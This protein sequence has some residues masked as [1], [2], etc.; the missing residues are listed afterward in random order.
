MHV[1]D[2]LAVRVETFQEAPLVEP[3]L[4]GPGLRLRTGLVCRAERMP[5][6]CSGRA[7]CVG[8]HQTVDRWANDVRL[9]AHGGQVCERSGQSRRSVHS[10]SGC[11]EHECPFRGPS[12]PGS[13]PIAWPKNTVGASERRTTSDTRAHTRSRAPVCEVG[14]HVPGRDGVQLATSSREARPP[15]RVNPRGAELPEAVGPAHAQ[16]ATHL[17]HFQRLS[18]RHRLRQAVGRVSAR[19][20]TLTGDEPLA[21]RRRPHPPSG[22]AAAQRPRCLGERARRARQRPRARAALAAASRQS[23]L[24]PWPAVLAAL[25]GAL[26]ALL[27]DAP[28]LV[29]GEP[30]VP[31]EGRTPR[32]PYFLA[33]LLD[34]RRGQAI[35]R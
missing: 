14:V 13:D 12:S 32:T 7:S 15:P 26:P 18:F 22:A 33:H 25:D 20:L 8:E 3:D 23:R 10:Q 27:A 30:G 21:R 31:T 19:G 1:P 16:G 2:D 4:D 29:R 11:A 6:R 28:G 5:R 9:D 34:R 35:T 24:P 17:T